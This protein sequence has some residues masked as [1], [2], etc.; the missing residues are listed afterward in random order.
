MLLYQVHSISVVV[1]SYNLENFILEALSSVYAQTHSCSEVILAD[2]NSTDSTIAL[3]KKYFPSV[4]ISKSCNRQSPLL[5]AFQGFS[6]SKGDLIFFLDGDDVWMPDKLERCV[7]EFDA[8]PTHFLVSHAHMRVDESLSPLLC[9]DA[10]S[11][12]IDRIFKGPKSLIQPR[13]RASVMFRKGFWLGSAYGFRRQCFDEKFFRDIVLNSPLSSCSYLDLVLGPYLAFTNPAGSIGYI[14]DH[15]FFYRIHQSNSA[16]SDSVFSQMSALRRMKATTVLTAKVLKAAGANPT[17]IYNTYLPILFYLKY[18]GF[19]L[20]RAPAMT[21]KYF[22]LSRSFILASPF[23]LLREILRLLAFV[24]P[25]GP[26][27]FFYCK[28]KMTLFYALS[29][30]FVAR[31][32]GL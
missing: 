26:R 1:I 28:K 32:R 14:H 5:N 23:S 11:R 16:A 7:S 25:F 31:F 18:I 12:N 24:F 6:R 17:E 9:S 21:A 27:I 19:L 29:H 4:V 30:R 3:V 8:N 10:T 20:V 22:I 2:D 15:H 13:L